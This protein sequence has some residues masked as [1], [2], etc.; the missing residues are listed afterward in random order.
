MNVAQLF[1]GHH[2]SPLNLSFSVIWLTIF[3]LLN[4]AWSPV[5]SM[6]KGKTR[7][8]INPLLL[9]ALLCS[10]INVVSGRRYLVLFLPSI[11]A[12]DVLL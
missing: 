10:P 12:R 2:A 3:T 7:Y 9:S 6:C 11:Y 1:W 4:N 5:T 8:L